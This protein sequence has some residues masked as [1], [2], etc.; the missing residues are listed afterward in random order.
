ME[1]AKSGNTARVTLLPQL[2]GKQA[3][4]V[5]G[6]AAAEFDMFILAGYPI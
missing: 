1:Q 4:F 5:L 2:C 6:D 3:R